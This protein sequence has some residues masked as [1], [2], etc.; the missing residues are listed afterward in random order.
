MMSDAEKSYVRTWVYMS[1]NFVKEDFHDKVNRL[2]LN[3]NHYRNIVLM[4][5]AY[6]EVDRMHFLL[7]SDPEKLIIF[8]PLMPE[9]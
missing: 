8:P 7:A 6:Y 3:S 2:P 5:R 1:L 4:C 9:D